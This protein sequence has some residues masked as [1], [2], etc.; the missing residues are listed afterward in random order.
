MG[1]YKR[2]DSPYWW[3][4]FKIDGRQYG[5]MSTNYTDEKL[6]KQKYE[7]TRTD[8]LRGKDFNTKSK[9]TLTELLEDYL[10]RCVDQPSYK[11]KLSHFRMFTAFF[12]DRLAKDITPEDVEDYREYRKKLVIESSINRE[13]TTLKNCFYKAIRA[14]K[15]G[16]NENP[17]AE[18]NY[19]N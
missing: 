5:P 3:M 4:K 13:L 1:I 18:L 7:A 17:L 8:I 6:A 10:K 16:F 9:I 12:K 14:K 2:H 19:Y 15:Y 11:T